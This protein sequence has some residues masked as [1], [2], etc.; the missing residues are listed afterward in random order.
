MQT[1]FLPSYIKEEYFQRGRDNLINLAN[2]M[3]VKLTIRN[4]YTESDDGFD[5]DF[6]KEYFEILMEEIHRL[7][8]VRRRKINILF[9]RSFRNKF[10]PEKKGD[11]ITVDHVNSGLCYMNSSE[12]TTNILIHREEEFYKVLVHEMLHLYNVIPHDFALDEH[13]RLLYGLEH[14]NTNE[15]LVELNALLFNNLIIHRMYDVPLDTLMK[16]EYVWSI[17]KVRQLFDHFGISIMDEV[18]TKWKESTHVFSYFVIKTLLLITLIGDMF[19]ED[20]LPGSANKFEKFLMTINDAKNAK[21][22]KDMIN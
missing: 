1:D 22:L 12:H 10:L 21:L 5:T 19:V 2:G 3:V 15:A 13:V 16:R 7:T 9:Y 11:V 6:F 8:S 17:R 14:V 20:I 4:L 18:R